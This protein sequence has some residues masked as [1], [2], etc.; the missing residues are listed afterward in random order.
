MD[1]I[2]EN[3]PGETS[4]GSEE[5]K[6]EYSPEFDEEDMWAWDIT[7]SDLEDVLERAHPLDLILFSGNTFFSKQSKWWRRKNM[8]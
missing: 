2:L 7:E 4:F 1:V 3:E 6:E 8:E 5:I